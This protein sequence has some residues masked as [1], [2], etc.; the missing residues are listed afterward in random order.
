MAF[1]VTLLALPVSAGITIPDQPLTTGNRVAPNILFI[2]D[3]SGSMAWANINSQSISKITGSGNFS[4]TPDADGVDTGTRI[5]PESTGSTRMYMQNY[6]TNTLYYNP[7]RNYQTWLQP[8]GNRMSGGTSYTNVYSDGNYVTY[9][10]ADTNGGGKNLSSKTQTFYVP[11]D[12]N[13]TS[14]AYLSKVDNYYRYQI[15]AGGAD[16]VR[17]EYGQV[18]AATYTAA[19]YP[20]TGQSASK[21][22]WI[23]YSVALPSNTTSVTAQTSNG[24]GD[25]DLYLRKSG[26]P[27]TSVYDCRSWGNNNNESCTINNPGTTVYVG[28]Y[29][30]KA[31]S[32]ATLTV[33]YSVTNSCDGDPNGAWGWINCTSATP[34]GRSVTAEKT[35][36]ATWYSYHRTRIKA[37]KA[38]AAE[39]FGGLGNKVRVGFRTIWN[40]NNFDIPVNDGNDGRFIDSTSPATTSRSTWFNRLFMSYASNGTPLQQALDDAGQYFMRTDAAGPYGPESGSDQLSCRQNFTILTTDGYWNTS[41]VSSGNVDGSSGT[42][43]KGPK[44]SY[45]YSPAAPYQDGY[46]NTLADIAMKYWVTDLRTEN[47]MGNASNPNNNNVPTSD[48]DPAFWQHMVTFTLALGLKTTKGWGSVAEATTALLAG[49][50]WP[51]PDTTNLSD[52]PKRLDDLLHAA[53]NGHG[54]FTPATSPDAFAQGL[55]KALAAITQR[56]SSFSN[57]TANSTSLNTGAQVFSASYVS[58][59]W[60]GALKAQAVS[61]TGVGA[62]SWTAT[63]P[64]VGSRKVFTA[65]GTPGQAGTSGATFPTSQQVTALDNSGVGPANYEVAGDKN[66]AYIKGDATLEERNGAG[67]LRNRPT[68]V[69]GDIVNS[70]PAYVPGGAAGDGTTAGTVYVGANDGMLHAFDAANGQELFA[71]VPNILDF[72]KLK[73]L[74]RGDYD[75]KFFV[76]GPV[77]VSPRSLTPGQNILVGTLGRGGKGL[78][79]LDVSNPTSFGPS[80]FKWERKDTPGNNMG[81]VVGAPVI[82]QVRNGTPVPAV[83]FGNGPNSTNDKAVLVVMNLSDG[84]VIKEIPTDNTTNNGL[85]APL[86]VYAADGKTLV[87]VYAGDMQGNLWKFDLRSTSPSAWT[88]TKVFH[89]EKTAGKPQPITG[90]LASAIDIKTNQRWIFFGTG[91][92]MTT[93]DAD[94]KTPASQTL[95]G[96]IDDGG[97]YPYTR[98][99]LTGRTIAVAGDYRYFEDPTPLP[100]ASK[101]WY[102]DLPGNG[103]R[104]IQDVQ[105]DNNFVVAAS[106]IPEGDACDASGSGFLNAIDAFTGTSGGKS[107]FDLDKNGSTD[108]TAAGGHP[109]GSVNLGV[110]M[111]TRPVLLPGVGVVDGSAGTGASSF[112]KQ[113]MRWQRVSWRE[114]RND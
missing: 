87:Y 70:S 19:G 90:G 9:A 31:F 56:T 60:T 71:Y 20:K 2:L 103:E 94:D 84:T 112:G 85:F 34:T 18:V 62:L 38:G 102:L 24:S 26:N 98:S 105:V 30:N 54:E 101:G 59:V 16:V 58:G 78:Y 49:D 95:Y 107:Y 93:S 50:T 109:I 67:N 73:Q 1:M 15:P 96:V 99:N 69:L 6:V 47:Y 8:D 97:S 36:F 86:G 65:S 42:T 72:S 64:A 13:N 29:A 28:L 32:G 82:A 81:Y 76:D 100:S 92:Y 68:T 108:D 83:I 7:F 55:N 4:S 23:Y 77:V 12:P 66:A 91:R 41:V 89:A 3:D 52:N 80:N 74:S 14:T 44:G 106:M 10:P 51:D 25:L 46:T 35:N 27:T 40:R 37:A 57:V 22:T 11:K 39:A 43:I 75:H 63:I 61:R 33:T 114:I 79:A 111:P 17:A 5:T 48:A 53:V 21:G 110:G 104:V 113:I 45:T 88:A